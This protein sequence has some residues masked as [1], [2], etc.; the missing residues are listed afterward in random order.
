MSCATGNDDD[1]S[2]MRPADLRP[3]SA[4]TCMELGPKVRFIVLVRFGLAPTEDQVDRSVDALHAAVQGIVGKDAQVKV[5]VV[6]SRRLES[7]VQL[8]EPVTVTL[9]AEVQGAS[10]GALS[11]LYSQNGI[12]SLMA[13]FSALLAEAGV[14]AELG[15]AQAVRVQELDGDEGSLDDSGGDVAHI[16]AASVSAIGIMLV[17]MCCGGYL[18]FRQKAFWRSAPVGDENC[19]EA[20]KK[21]E[22]GPLLAARGAASR[23]SMHS[24]AASFAPSRGS[25]LSA[26]LPRCEVAQSPPRK[27]SFDEVG[28]T[29]WP[30]KTPEGDSQGDSTSYGGESHPSEAGAGGVVRP[31]RSGTVSE[32]TPRSDEVLSGSSLRLTAAPEGDLGAAPPLAA[33]LRPDA[34]AAEQGKSAVGAQQTTALHQ[35]ASAGQAIEVEALLLSGAVVD[36]IDHEKKT[37]LHL[38]ALGGYCEVAEALLRSG[39]VV[40]ARDGHNRTPFQYGAEAG[41]TDI[42]EV[43]LENGAEDEDDEE[44]A[45]QPGIPQSAGTPRQA[46]DSNEDKAGSPSLP[47][48]L[49]PELRPSHFLMETGNGRMVREVRIPPPPPPPPPRGSGLALPPPTYRTCQAA[50]SHSSSTLAPPREPHWSA[51]APLAAPLGAPPGAP[52]SS[53]QRAGRGHVA[54]NCDVVLG[55]R[56]FTSLAAAAPPTNSPTAAASAVAMAPLFPARG[57]GGLTSSG[58]AASQVR[59]ARGGVRLPYLSREAL[60]EGGSSSPLGADLPPLA[61]PSALA[62]GVGASPAAAR[63]ASTPSSRPST[64]PRRSSRTSSSSESLP[65]IPGSSKAKRSQ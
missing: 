9:E 57:G 64:T 15:D 8:G 10:M 55:P 35:A 4:G 47:S 5:R 6:T 7:S 48:V 22:A 28:K 39:A 41:H 59:L 2:A 21:K 52:P 60:P 23:F 16:V 50:A 53:E 29:A 12:D 40:N 43:L 1:C 34:F 11:F 38:A 27:D 62:P 56:P 54:I 51:G 37:P 31:S 3:C 14:D 25:T 24:L 33:G 61:A 36:A 17:C 46:A 42:I 30:E 18:V 32:V 63:R 44:E 20:R 13:G 45:W 19:L 58:A 49:L 26:S 65:T